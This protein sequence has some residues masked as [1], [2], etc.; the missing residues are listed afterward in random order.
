M[1]WG[2]LIIAGLTLHTCGCISSDARQAHQLNQ[3]GVALLMQKD[4]QGAKTQFEQAY[5]LTPQ[6]PDTLYNLASSAQ[7][8][9]QNAVAENYYRQCLA[10][11]PKHARAQHGLLVLYWSEGKTKEVERMT[12]QRIQE[13][14]QDPDALTARAWYLRETGDLPA[15]QAMLHRAL[16]IQP[17]HS[18]AMMELGILY[19][20]YNYPDRSRSLYQQVLRQE[21]YHAEARERL[22]V[23]QMRAK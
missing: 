18:Q 13:Q 14:A 16:E 23:L 11:N 8:L 3:Q 10:K 1:R 15:A 7:H 17:D 4:Y 20:I 22:M 9:G 2:S 6:D 19:E 21:P 5:R 12:A